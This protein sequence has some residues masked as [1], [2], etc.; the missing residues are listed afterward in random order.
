MV[1]A[2]KSPKV[3]VRT[4]PGTALAPVASTATV[5]RATWTAWVPKA[6]LSRIRTWSPR[7]ERKITLRTV[8]LVSP[9]PAGQVEPGMSA[10]TT[11][12]APQAVTQWPPAAGR[13]GP[14][15]TAPARGDACAPS[16]M[17]AAPVSAATAMAAP[18][19]DSDCQRDSRGADRGRAM[20]AF[21]IPGVLPALH[22]TSR[23]KN[24]HQ[25]GWTSGSRRS[26]S[27]GEE[28]PRRLMAVKLPGARPSLRPC[29]RWSRLRPGPRRPCVV[30]GGRARG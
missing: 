8:W 1:T 22:R 2:G 27:S 19:R 4:L 20:L 26:P 3:S 9:V 25:R 13:A 14:A 17:R 18:A 29:L 16:G 5:A 23:N 6:L 28:P 24:A 7:A 21:T 12:L 30:G 10:P 15:G 11:G